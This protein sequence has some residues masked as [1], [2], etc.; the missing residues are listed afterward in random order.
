VS[1]AGGGKPGIRAFWDP[2]SQQEV[3]TAGIGNYS[4]VLQDMKSYI[5]KLEKR[6]EELETAYME[7]KLLGS[8][9]GKI[10]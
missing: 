8:D 1:G 3:M 5:E 6:I 2:E 4:D 10:E 7:D 9:S